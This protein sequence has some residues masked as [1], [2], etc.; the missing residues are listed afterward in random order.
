VEIY[1][2]AAQRYLAYIDYDEASRVRARRGN[3]SQ[4]VRF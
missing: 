4:N 1:R 2:G 3:H